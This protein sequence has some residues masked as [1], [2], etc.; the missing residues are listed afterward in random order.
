MASAAEMLRRLSSLNNI[1]VLED[2]V[3]AEILENESELVDIKKEEY[4]EGNIYSDGSAPYSNTSKYYVSGK[5]KY[6]KFKNKL[7][8]KPGLGTVDL[9]LTG[10]YIESFG[11]KRKFNKYNFN[12][13]NWKT[14][15]LK[16]QYNT[17]GKDILGLK[18]QKFN[19]FQKEII[20]PRFVR[21]LQSI[22]NKK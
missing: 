7:N 1:N 9:L 22:I 10:A 13:T 4:R 5:E 3:Y 18:Q 2:M 11:V 14:E 16:D 12:A 6:Y 20:K 15:K 17:N 21:K 8:P 19:Q